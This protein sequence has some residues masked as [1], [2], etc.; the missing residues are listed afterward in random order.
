[1]AVRWMIA[2]VAPETADRATMALWN[3][4]RVMTADGRRSSW[5]RSTARRPVATPKRRRSDE[6]AGAVPARGSV[7]PSASRTQPMVEA[8][9]I[10]MHVPAVGHSSVPTSVISSSS[11]TPPRYSPPQAAT[12]CTCA[13]PLAAPGAGHHRADHQRDCRDVRG[14]RCHQL[15]RTEGEPRPD[16]SSQF[17]NHNRTRGRSRQRLHPLYARRCARA[18][19][20][21]WSNEPAPRTSSPPSTPSTSATPCCPPR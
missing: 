16:T 8:V 6:T 13:E 7:M 20:A 17:A 11:S 21:S 3:T 19:P 10:T 1:M 9:P 18:H 4:A 12:V 2:F 14:S 5:T 15:G